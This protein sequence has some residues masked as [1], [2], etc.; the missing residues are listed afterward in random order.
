MVWNVNSQARR[1][2]DNEA[3]QMIKHFAESGHSHIQRYKCAQ[4]RNL[5]KQRRK[6]YKYISERNAESLNFYYA[7]FTRQI[8][9]VSTEQ[10]RVGVTS[11][12]NR[13]LGR[14]QCSR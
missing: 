8:S 13:C 14:H 10:G 11:S 12:L 4:P 3:N 5:E 9:S 6:K 2:M 7:H 1:K